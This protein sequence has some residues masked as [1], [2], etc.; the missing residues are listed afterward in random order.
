MLKFVF[1]QKSI[2]LLTQQKM[3]LRALSFVL[4]ALKNIFD[5]TP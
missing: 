4:E 5:K 3:R 1:V 2:D